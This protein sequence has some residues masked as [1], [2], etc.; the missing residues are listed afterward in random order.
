MS[1]RLR[2]LTGTHAGA[3]QNL[4]PGTHLVG[5]DHECK[6]CISDWSKTAKPVELVVDGSK[7][8][9]REAGAPDH[10]GANAIRDLQPERFGDLV[11]CIGPADQPWPTDA[12]LLMRTFG[13]KARLH[14]AMRRHRKLWVGAAFATSTLALVGGLAQAM[15]EDGGPQPLSVEAL[16]AEVS[17]RATTL[18][19]TELRIEALP[20]QG[21]VAVSGLVPDGLQALRLRDAIDRVDMQRRVSHLYA[22]ATEVAVA[23]QGGLALPN[24]TVE[25]KGGGV[26]MVAGT[27]ADIDALRARVKQLSVDMGSAVRR[28]DISALEAHDDQLPVGASALTGD[29]FSVLNT[30]DGVKHLNLSAS[31]TLPAAAASN[32]ADNFASTHPASGSLGVVSVN[33]TGVTADSTKTP[34]QPPLSRSVVPSPLNLKELQ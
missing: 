11:L 14:S 17:A 15:T 1:K 16:A 19:L 3:E 24:I 10:G 13:V 6:I 30:R 21:V 28:I 26:F 27:V 12:E 33:P 5:G 7:C 18:G 23:I 4:D 31:P 22:V 25:H 32:A 20:P 8:F 9:W 29:D 34:N 2:V